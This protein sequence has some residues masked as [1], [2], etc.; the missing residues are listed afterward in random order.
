MTIRLKDGTRVIVRAMMLVLLSSMP[1][2][3]RSEDVYQQPEQFIEDSF[4]GV[5]P[6]SSVL[7]IT[8]E[9]RPSIYEILGHDLDSLRVRYWAKDDRT[10]WIL[11]EIGKERPITVGLVV[12]QNRLEQL[13]VL[14]Y[15]ESRGGEVRYPFFTDQFLNMRLTEDNTFDDHI[16]G[17][18][19]ATLS[20]RALKKIAA[21][22]LYFHRLVAPEQ[23]NRGQD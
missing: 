14:I 19:G 13:K 6:E 4:D 22:A 8:K 17:I 15:R 16:D 23:A 1:C 7:W 3:T 10:V 18:S 12:K 11:N 21:L 2:V 9:I 5:T 20:V